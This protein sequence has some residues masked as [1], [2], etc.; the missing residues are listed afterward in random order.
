MGRGRPRKIENYFDAKKSN[1]QFSEGQKSKG[2]LDDF[3]QAIV[4]NT[5]E[6]TI[7]KTPVNAKD[8][9]NKDY[10]DAAA[11]APEGTAVLS[12]GEGGATKY[13]RE[14]GDGTCSWQTPAAGGDVTAAANL[15]D[16]TIV[17]GDGGA[18]GVK[19]STATVAQ[20]ATNVTHVAGDGSDHANVAT[21][22]VHISSD[23]TNHANVVLNDTHRGLT[24]EHLDWTAD[25]GATNIHANN[26]TDTNTQLSQENV[27]DYAGALVSNATGT[28][29]G[30]TITYQDATGDMDFVV[31]HDAATNFVADEHLDWKTDRGADNIH[32]N[33]I[34]AVPEAAVTAHVA[35]IDH[36][37]CLNFVAN[38]HI[39]WTA[40]QG[41]TNIHNGNFVALQ[42]V[43][44]DTSPELGGEMDCGAHTIGFTQQ[45]T[46]GDGTTTIN[47]ALGNKFKFTF[48][49][50][51]DTF[52]FTA[53]SNPCNILLMLIQD[54]TGS[55]TATWPATVK[56]P[57]AT[58]PTLTTAANAID[59]IAFYYDG[60]NY[61]GETSKA[62][63]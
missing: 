8:I 9:A 58:A 31:D 13:L 38:E 45:S 51:N 17:Q 6:G 11:G 23:G 54:G 57:A 36:D 34:T 39:D 44:E 26:Y 46:T 52:T 15:T 32:V 50:Q 14:D 53:P 48:G 41:A 21:N 29:T 12:T 35:A 33:N 30:I 56:W 60:T 42:N 28:H 25:L 59:I 10:V 47:W 1:V 22:T 5:K 43:V 4:V 16:A 20:I 18:K 55:R 62:F 27:E 40:D 49:A 3:H 7:Q 37:S 61:Y 19:T 63:G 24:N 2:I